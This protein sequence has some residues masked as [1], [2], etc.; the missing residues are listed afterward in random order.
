MVP[1]SLWLKVVLIDS[2]VWAWTAQKTNAMSNDTQS[3]FIRFPL[4]N[5]IVADPR[6]LDDIVELSI[7]PGELR[8]VVRGSSL[9]ATPFV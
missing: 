9:S 8:I 2:G 5:P 4:G 1:A 3:C 7:R 6:C